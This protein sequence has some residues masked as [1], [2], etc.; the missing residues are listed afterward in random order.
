[1]FFNIQIAIKKLPFSLSRV[2]KVFLFLFFDTLLI[3]MQKRQLQSKLVY[4][5]RLDN[6][7][8]FFLWLDSARQIHDYYHDHKIILMA[9]SSFSDFARTLPYWDEVLSVDVA[10]LERNIWYRWKLLSSVRHKG[11]ETVIYPIYSR[12]FLTGDTVVRAIGSDKRIGSVGDLSNISKWEK[13]LADCWYTDL[14]PARIEPLMELERNAEFLH[15]MGLPIYPVSVAHLP[16]LK[17]TTKTQQFNFPYFILFPGASWAGKIWPA[18]FFAQCAD[19]IY[20]HHNWKAIICGGPE[21]IANSEL[22]RKKISSHQAV[23]M[24]GKTNLLELVDL[25]RQAKIL[26]GNDTSGVHIAAVVETP[27]ICIL[28]GGHF[29]RFLPYPAKIEG[30]NPIPIFHHMECF[31][32]NWRCSQPHTSGEAVPCVQRVDLHDVIVAVSGVFL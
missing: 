15:N 26:I 27:S 10:R 18:D 24:V 20:A 9:N 14:L 31:G 13:K 28:G 25:I 5:I 7:G 32:C 19:Y 2:I 17:K 16:N 21:N 29:G 22:I 23:N 8:D 6:I 12:A 11:A 30:V 1:M 4:L 3:L